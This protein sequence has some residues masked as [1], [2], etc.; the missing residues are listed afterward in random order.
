MRGIEW[1]GNVEDEGRGRFCGGDGGVP[2]G[3]V[4]SLAIAPYGPRKLRSHRLSLVESRV[5]A[6]RIP[7]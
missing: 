3:V 4:T 7:R 1:R 6:L 2:R 5:S